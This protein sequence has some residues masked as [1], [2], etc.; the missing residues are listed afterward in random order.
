MNKIVRCLMG[1]A[2]TFTFTRRPC[3]AHHIVVRDAKVAWVIRI[4]AVVVAEMSLPY[5]DVSRPTAPLM[6]ELRR[7]C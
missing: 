2:V 1:L 7:R 5:F 4:L 6:A 3:R